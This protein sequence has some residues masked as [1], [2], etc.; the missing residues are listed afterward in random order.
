LALVL[1]MPG[2]RD[3]YQFVPLHPVNI[4]LCLSAGL[5]SA[6]WFEIL[7]RVRRQGGHFPR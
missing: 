6:L 4:A 5:A 7:K 1:V 2:L 3:L